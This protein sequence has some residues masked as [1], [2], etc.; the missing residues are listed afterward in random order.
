LLQRAPALAHVAPDAPQDADVGVRI[1]E[2]LQ[3]EALA[4]A[5]AGQQQNSFDDHD[6]SWSDQARFAAPQVRSK[7]VDGNEDVFA[8]SEAIEIFAQALVVERVRMIE[9]QA[10]ALREGKI[11]TR[12][13][14]SVV[15]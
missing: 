4:Q 13:V 9:V 6:G 10:F 7:V 2:Q 3:V 14:V 1:H 15:G 11:R 12:L 5:D 8:V